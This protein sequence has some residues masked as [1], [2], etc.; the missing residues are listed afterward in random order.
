MLAFTVDCFQAYQWRNR[1]M[2]SGREGQC[3]EGLAHLQPFV[4]LKL[5]V[6]L[7]RL[8]HASLVI[9]GWSVRRHP[10]TA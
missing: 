5:R 10:C 6:V 9:V 4:S 1:N 3:S 7:P 2:L 8:L